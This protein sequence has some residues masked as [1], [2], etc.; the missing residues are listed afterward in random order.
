MFM[1]QAATDIVIVKSANVSE[2]Y[3]YQVLAPELRAAGVPL[4]H[5]HFAVE[6]G[7]TTWLVI[8]HVPGAATVDTTS[9]EVLAILASLHRVRTKPFAGAFK[10][11]WTPLLTNR[12]LAE[13]PIAAS[14][15]HETL[16][17]YEHACHR[18]FACNTLVSG[19][20][21]PTN[22]G[23][24]AT[25]DTVLYD[26]DRLGFAHPAVDL[27]IAVP[28]LGSMADFERVARSYETVTAAT[29]TRADLHRSIAAAKVWSVLTFVFFD[30][31]AT[32][33][34]RATAALV[35]PKLVPWLQSLASR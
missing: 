4:P 18:L 25:G 29:R 32:A 23:L 34:G 28:G 27:A 13:L 33:Q 22:W 35:R 11:A 5:L 31:Q 10:P 2:R 24:R 7:A 6:D 17:A 15:L 26:W 21:N 12:V 16:R 8:E 3:A 19:D 20:P 9:P 1:V 30:G 14:G